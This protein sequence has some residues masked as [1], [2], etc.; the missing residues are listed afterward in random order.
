MNRATHIYN[1]LKNSKNVYKKINTLFFDKIM[2]MMSEKITEDKIRT[3]FGLRTFEK[4][5]RYFYEGRVIRGIVYKNKLVSFV[6]GTAEKPYKV[7]IDLSS[8]DFSNKCSCP[9]GGD[10]KHVVATLLSWIHSPHIYLNGNEILKKISSLSKDE[11]LKILDSV[12]MLR[13]SILTTFSKVLNIHPFYKLKINEEL[14]SSYKT[15]VSS[16][17]LLEIAQLGFTDKVYIEL[18]TLYSICEWLIENNRPIDFVEIII[19]LLQQLHYA[20][21]YYFN[22][23]I[24]ELIDNLHNLVTQINWFAVIENNRHLLEL[25]FEYLIE[26]DDTEIVN[27]LISTIHSDKYDI[28]LKYIDAIVKKYLSNKHYLDIKKEKIYELAI[29]LKIE[30]LSKISESYLLDFLKKYKPANFSE[31]KVLIQK[32]Y[33]SNYNDLLLQYLKRAIIGIL[34]EEYALNYGNL[35]FMMDKL[36]Y[37]SRKYTNF[38]DV[39]GEDNIIS[40]MIKLANEYNHRVLEMIHSALKALNLLEK[41][42]NKIKQDSNLLPLRIRWN[43]KFNFQYAVELVANLIRKNKAIPE[44]LI[45]DI[46]YKLYTQYTKFNKDIFSDKNALFIMKHSIKND[47]I[48]AFAR[49]DLSG[50]DISLFLSKLFNRISDAEINEIINNILNNKERIANVDCLLA[51]YFAVPN[52]YNYK[53]ILFRTSALILPNVNDIETVHRIANKMI[54]IDLQLVVDQYLLWIHTHVTK[55]HTYYNN[56]AKLLKKIKKILQITNKL[57]KWET[58]KKDITQRYKTRKKFMG[59]IRDILE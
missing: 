9:L 16:Y 18:K 53:D 28:F 58:I 54:N 49:Y 8:D 29:Y 4:G 46:I 35:S 10:C 17:E 38:V 13:P 20:P 47:C 42:E 15:F 5:K 25:I 14:I 19:P 7:E 24:F 26:I 22:H 3:I 31:L 12:I 21:D 50:R 48:S 36:M 33:A 2:K 11:I 39:V 34:K 37:A 52:N 59:L 43:I 23:K 30:T 57:E 44:E 6:W 51:L 1:Y 56:A 32:A 40:L 55:S 27:T 41:F 45:D